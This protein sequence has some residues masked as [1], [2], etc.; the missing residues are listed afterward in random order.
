MFSKNK[1]IQPNEPDPYALCCITVLNSVVLFGHVLYDMEITP[2]V[3]MSKNLV[4]KLYGRDISCLG[5]RYNHNSGS[6][7][8]LL[9]VEHCIPFSKGVTVIASISKNNGKETITIEHVQQ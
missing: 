5:F 8:M 3:S 6:T 2:P 9:D 1:N 4:V 7:K